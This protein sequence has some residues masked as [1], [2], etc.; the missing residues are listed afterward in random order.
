MSFGIGLNQ[1]TNG[2]QMGADAAGKRVI[3]V[4]GNI[5]IVKY[6]VKAVVKNESNMSDIEA[7]THSV[8]M[9]L[10]APSTGGVAGHVG[11]CICCTCLT[12]GGFIGGAVVGAVG[13]SFG[14][15]IFLVPGI[16]CWVIGNQ[17]A[18]DKNPDNDELASNLLIAGKVLTGF[19]AVAAGICGIVGGAYGGM[20]GASCVYESI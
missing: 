6:F 1:L 14:A 10:P 16:I 18:N 2:I 3:S 12:V 19:G 11:C 17:D 15:A 5:P 20:L 7:N 9:G 13:G 4:Y 8:A